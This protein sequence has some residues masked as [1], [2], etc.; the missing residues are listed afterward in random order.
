MEAAHVASAGVKRSTKSSTDLLG[1]DLEYIGQIV[2]LQL[3]I[4]SQLVKKRL[5]P[6]VA[7]VLVNKLAKLVGSTPLVMASTYRFTQGLD[8]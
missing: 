6:M 2:Q 3:H 1:K 4:W 5:Y 7:A 8:G